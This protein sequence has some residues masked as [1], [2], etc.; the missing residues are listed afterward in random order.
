LFYLITFVIWSLRSLFFS[1]ERQGE[2]GLNEPEGGKELR[3]AE[4]VETVNRIYCSRNGCISIKERKM[5]N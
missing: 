2:V 5:Q 4:G 1:H 3:E